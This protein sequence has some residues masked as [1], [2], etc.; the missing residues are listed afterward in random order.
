MVTFLRQLEYNMATAKS[1]HRKADE[2]F[3]EF[4]DLNQ[5]KLKK[6]QMRKSSSFLTKTEIDDDFLEFNRE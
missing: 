1:T 2:K 5:S 6:K 3:Q 4:M